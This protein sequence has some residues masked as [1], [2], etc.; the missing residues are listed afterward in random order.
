VYLYDVWLVFIIF[1]SRVNLVHDTT[2][3]RVKLCNSRIS[4]A[5][6]HARPLNDDDTM[7]GTTSA[8]L[9]MACGDTTGQ[10]CLAHVS[11]GSAVDMANWV[12]G[13]RTSLINRDTASTIESNTHLIQVHRSH[14]CTRALSTVTFGYK[15][16]S[17]AHVYMC[18]YDG[19][20]RC[21]NL[22]NN[23]FMQVC[24]CHCFI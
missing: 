14:P 4:S 5:A 3:H 18:S 10:L 2:K 19:T 1:F 23:T 24:V 22:I 15:Q 21:L 9:V 7:I 11:V 20:I 6:F 17:S 8:T 13:T 12:K 16:K